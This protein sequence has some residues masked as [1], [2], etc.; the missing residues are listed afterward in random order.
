MGK[1]Y[2]ERHVTIIQI[3]KITHPILNLANSIFHNIK[4]KGYLKLLTF[5]NCEAH[6]YVRKLFVYTLE[7]SCRSCG[8]VKTVNIY[9]T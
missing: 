7:C 3:Q 2:P 9:F 6:N 4:P 1:Q 5:H 8:S